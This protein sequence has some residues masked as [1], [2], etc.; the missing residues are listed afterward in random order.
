MRIPTCALYTLLVLL[1]ISAVSA[2]EVSAVIN[3]KSFHID[4]SRD[5]NEENY[6]L[7]V[8]YRFDSRSR[9]RSV[10]M[11]NAFR[12]SKNNMSYMAGAGLHRNLYATERLSGFYIDAGLN[13]F[14]MTRDN[15]DDGKPFPGALPSMTIGN[16]YV[17]AN[18]TYLPRAAIK[19]VVAGEAMDQA[20]SGICFMQLKL[21]LSAILA[22]F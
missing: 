6:G 8:E 2:G 11:A 1:P 5:W 12:D 16:R 22:T 17:G 3:G 14:T 7:G 15:I 13:V 10:L 4:S 21:N 9:W 19:E 18:I 20:M